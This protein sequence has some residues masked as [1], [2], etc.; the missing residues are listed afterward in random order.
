MKDTKININWD[1]V[2]VRW[3]LPGGR[4]KGEKV[5]FCRRARNVKCEKLRPATVNG[6]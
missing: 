6:S 3:E 2:A 4:N 1:S 5:V